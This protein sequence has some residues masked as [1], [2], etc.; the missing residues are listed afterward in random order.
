MNHQLTLVG[1]GK[2]TKFPIALVGSS[3]WS[4]LITWMRGTMLAAGNIGAADLSLFRVAD[5][6]D[7]VVRVIRKAREESS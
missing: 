5:N 1:T 6:P 2:I 4:G 7:E 3:Y